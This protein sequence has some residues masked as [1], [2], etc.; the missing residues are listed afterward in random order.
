MAAEG[1]AVALHL[2]VTRDEF[3]EL[4][5]ATE[6]QREVLAQ[7]D[8]KI[9]DAE[10]TAAAARE[11]LGAAAR[12]VEIERLLRSGADEA[13]TQETAVRQRE[14]EL[15]TQEGLSALSREHRAELDEARQ[16]LPDQKRTRDGEVELS[17]RA[18]AELTAAAD[19]AQS[20]RALLDE[21]RSA[22]RIGRRLRGLPD[23][24]LQANAADEASRQ[25][26]LK[27]AAA[28]EHKA[29]IERLDADIASAEQAITRWENLPTIPDQEAATATARRALVAAE[30]RLV[31][32]KAT[33]TSL[34]EELAALG[35]PVKNFAALHGKEPEA[36][37]ADYDALVAHRDGTARPQL[38][39]AERTIDEIVSWLQDEIRP[40][41]ELLQQSELTVTRPA[42]SPAAMVEELE[43]QLPAARER[44]GGTTVQGLQT[45]DKSLE[46]RLQSIEDRVRAIDEELQRVEELV[47]ARATVVATTLTRAYKRDSVRKRSFDTVVLDEASMAPIPALWVAAALA[48]ANVVLVGDPKQL[49]PIKHSDHELAEKWLGRDVFDAARVTEAVPLPPH[50]IQLQEQFR[51]HPNISAIPNRFV[52]NGDLRNGPNV[53]TTLRWT[54]GTSPTGGTTPLFFSSTPALSTPG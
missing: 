40:Q 5:S 15:R 34:H 16:R 20:T 18:V 41:Y 10:S 19:E 44:I 31:A 11:T 1:R 9:V 8:K 21:T 3:S 45:E 2:E 25:L 36:S 39:A 7:L 51:M 13:T 6:A 32:L 43:L 52:Y 33:A 49:P 4:E 48:T 23:P 50:C 17:S 22:S 38:E 12:R 53:E 30:D 26:G 29:E 42:S 37:L 28:E 35:D 24:E 14:D 46:T 27:K 47:I 54:A